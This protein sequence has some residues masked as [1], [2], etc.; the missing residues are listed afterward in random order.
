MASHGR[1]GTAWLLLGSETNK[2][3]TQCKRPL[4]VCRWITAVYA[5]MVPGKG[6]ENPPERRYCS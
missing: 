5:K 3:L 4:P 1:R 2:V 6:F